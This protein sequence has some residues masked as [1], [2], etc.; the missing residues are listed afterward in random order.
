MSVKSAAT[1]CCLKIHLIVPCGLIQCIP[2]IPTSMRFWSVF[3]T[4]MHRVKVNFIKPV[5]VDIDMLYVQ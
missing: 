3:Q 1:K 4:I 2:I 5:C